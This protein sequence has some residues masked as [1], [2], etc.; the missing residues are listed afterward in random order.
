MTIISCEKYLKFSKW[1]EKRY[2]KNGI[3]VISVGGI[4]S[5]YTALD[6]LAFKKYNA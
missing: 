6:I 2:R 4:P 1:L 5:R 3:L